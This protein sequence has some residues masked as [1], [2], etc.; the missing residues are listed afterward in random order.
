MLQMCMC[1]ES[2]RNRD[3]RN[4]CYTRRISMSKPQST[5]SQNVLKALSALKY[6]HA[7]QMRL[8]R[9]RSQLPAGEKKA[10]TTRPQ[11]KKRQIRAQR[12]RLAAR[13]DKMAQCYQKRYRHLE[14]LQVCS[15]QRCGQPPWRSVFE[16]VGI[17]FL[18]ICKVCY[19]HPFHYNK[20]L[21]V[22]VSLRLTYQPLAI[23]R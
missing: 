4:S 6:A 7:G 13:H 21:C 17:D 23:W 12:L 9:A 1:I 14:F 11:C 18:G 16:V 2:G 22:S 3:H 8:P 20:S 19:E 5:L 15:Q 10:I